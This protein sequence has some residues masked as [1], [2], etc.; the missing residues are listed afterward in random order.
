[1]D[2]AEAFIFAFY[3]PL[4]ILLGEERFVKGIDPFCSIFRSHS[5]ILSR[6]NHFAIGISSALLGFAGGVRFAF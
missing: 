6:Q 3:S 1:M 4:R 5:P 2:A